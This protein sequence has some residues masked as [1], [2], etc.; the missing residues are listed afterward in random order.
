MRNRQ[1]YWPICWILVCALGCSE[2]IDSTG[3]DGSNSCIQTQIEV[4]DN[5]IRSIILDSSDYERWVKLHLDDGITE[6]E[7][8][9]DLAIRRFEIRI[10]GAE[11][12][13][14]YGLGQSVAGDVFLE[15]SVA[16][17]NEWTF[18]PSD[19]DNLV[20]SSWYDYNPT[21]HQLTPADKT[22]FVRSYDG[23]RY[24]AVIVQDYYSPPPASDSGCMRLS[25][26]SV[27]APNVEPE[28][29]S[30]TGSL[31]TEYEQ[32]G[33]TDST[34]A[35]V[36]EDTP[37]AGCY[38]GPP[39]HMCDC[40]VTQADCDDTEGAWTDECGCNEQD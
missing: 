13:T 25:W 23:A 19:K 5:E 28:N 20:F 12:G 14:G 21:T 38:S 36:S 34:D 4:D 29:I 10:N 31:P 1:S 6:D 9:W 8:T 35:D 26:K 17:N 22:Y 2:S 40:Q 37:G 30:G 15:T 18:D 11:S 39:L 7:G 3:Q 24:Y 32:P 27:E 16:P 33:M